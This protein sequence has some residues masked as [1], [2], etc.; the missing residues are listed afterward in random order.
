[1]KTW[2]EFI[3]QEMQQDYFQDLAAFLTK[4]YA[5]KTIFP[6][7][8]H[9]FEAFKCTPYQKVKV[10]LLGQDPYHGQGQ[11]QGLSFSVNASVPIPPSLMNM[12]KE[13]Y[14]D[15]A[16]P[17]SNSGDLHPWATQ[18]VLLLN[19]VLTVE[20]GKANSHRHYG[21]EIFTD[22]VLQA[23]NEKETPIVFLLFGASAQKKEGLI[24]QTKHFIVKAPHPSPLS[25][26]RGF[27]NSHP[28]SKTNEYLANSG[29]CPIQWELSF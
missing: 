19:T 13:L 10:V 9:I 6:P 21:W 2:E 1:M 4:E 5:S 3:F 12:F 28:F 7:K 29:Q 20:E 11:A 16:I 17:I 26:Y 15:L 22:H 23:L 14:N 25:A 8:E 18:G 24:D 27:F